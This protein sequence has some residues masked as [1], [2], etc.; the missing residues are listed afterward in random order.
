MAGRAPAFGPPSSEDV[1][2]ARE[3]G[4]R[5][6]SAL[7][8]GEPVTVSVRDSAGDVVLPAQA[9]PI[10]S[11][12]LEGI[13]SGREITL[14]ANDSEL[15]VRQAADFLNVSPRYVERLLDEKQIPHASRGATRVVR[16]GDLVLYKDDV[17][18]KRREALDELVAE[19]QQ[20]GMGY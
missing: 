4:D 11:E 12:I 16:L 1:A 18:R 20:L 5:L 13:A 9:V 10:L 7:R 8:R 3:S 2:R 6:S 17:D 19:A 15:T 14:V